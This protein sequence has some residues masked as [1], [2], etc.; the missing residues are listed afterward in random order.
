MS[1]MNRFEFIH[2]C[3]I[4]L[5][6]THEENYDIYIERT[7]LSEKENRS[8]TIRWL[9]CRQDSEFWDYVLCLNL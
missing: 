5:S 2:S 4:D 1:A 8:S 9:Q 7:K 6:S 3:D